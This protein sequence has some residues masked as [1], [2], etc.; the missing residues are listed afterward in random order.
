MLITTT[1]QQTEAQDE[2]LDPAWDSS[3][4][5]L[6][7]PIAK[8]STRGLGVSWPEITAFQ[9]RKF[10]G[11]T[12][13]LSEGIPF[14]PGGLNEGEARNLVYLVIDLNAHSLGCLELERFRIAKKS[15]SFVI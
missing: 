7:Q 6:K 13:S 11:L 1:F 4:G 2:P 12:D 14:L 3:A 5:S 9:H 8:V 15:F 10:N